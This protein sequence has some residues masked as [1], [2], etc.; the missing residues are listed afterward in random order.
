MDSPTSVKT[1]ASV[2]RGPTLRGGRHRAGAGR[3]MRRAP[4]S[5]RSRGCSGYNEEEMI[6][7]TTQESTQFE[8]DNEKVERQEV[9]PEFTRMSEKMETDD[10][11]KPMYQHGEETFGD[12]L[13]HPRQELEAHHHRKEEF[14]TRVGRWSMLQSQN[15][16]QEIGDVNDR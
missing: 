10:H 12:I 1:S 11:G 8:E 9:Y 4:P 16:K 14:Q 13:T 15:T 5:P 2:R 3:S 7:L 6:G